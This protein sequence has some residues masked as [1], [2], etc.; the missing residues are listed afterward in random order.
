VALIQDPFF[1]S[2]QGQNWKSRSPPFFRPARS[3]EADLQDGLAI[4][5]IWSNL[6]GKV[7]RIKG[8]TK[9]CP[10]NR[11]F[12]QSNATVVSVEDNSAW[13]RFLP[14]Y[15]SCIFLFDLKAAPSR[16]MILW[17]V[18]IQSSAMVMP[19]IPAPIMQMS[20]SMIEWFFQF[21]LR[22]YACVRN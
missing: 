1:S 12:H 20:P 21:L 4:H 6:F 9:S 2:S 22:L 18:W 7:N 15:K 19:A 8:W 10:M 14:L 3:K 17:G 11:M 13:P 5:C 16:R